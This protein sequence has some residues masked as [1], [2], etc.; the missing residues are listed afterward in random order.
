M[1]NN[2][3]LPKERLKFFPIMMFATVMGMSGLTIMYQKASQWLLFPSWISTVLMV[4]TTGLFAKKYGI[5]ARLTI[6]SCQEVCIDSR[7]A[8]WP[9]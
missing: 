6:T 8:E 3:D 7:F 1:E 2:H 9:F 4:F 5:R